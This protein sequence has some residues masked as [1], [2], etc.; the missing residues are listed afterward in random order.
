MLTCVCALGEWCKCCLRVCVWAKE[1]CV[2]PPFSL[3]FA[4]VRSCSSGSLSTRGVT[5]QSV[6]LLTA[7]ESHVTPVHSPTLQTQH[8][9]PMLLPTPQHHLPSSLVPLSPLPEPIC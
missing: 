1:R 7:A 6:F 8:T 5:V 9:L 3:L 4:S 2:M